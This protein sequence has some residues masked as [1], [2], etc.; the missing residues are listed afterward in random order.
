[1]GTDHLLVAF[2]LSMMS[3]HAHHFCLIVR[4]DVGGPAT[5]HRRRSQAADVRRWRP[6]S[7]QG[8][9]WRRSL[10][11][12]KALL[13]RPDLLC[14]CQHPAWTLKISNKQLC[15]SDAES[16]SFCPNAGDQG[17]GRAGKAGKREKQESHLGGSL[18]AAEVAMM[19]LTP[20]ALV[21]G[22]PATCL[23]VSVMGARM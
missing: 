19:S 10:V 1:M 16:C 4:V 3:G 11:S 5:C 9:L 8:Q 2:R 14:T 18:S 23:P 13:L 6:Q 17:C 12:L 7:R 15:A 21:P 22:S 20:V